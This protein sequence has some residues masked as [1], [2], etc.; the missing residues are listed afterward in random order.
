MP[1]TGRSLSLLLWRPPRRRRRVSPFLEMLAAVLVVGVVVGSFLFVL[2]ARL[3]QP[4]GSAP[5]PTSTP[6]TIPT[7]VGSPSSPTPAGPANSLQT[8]HMIDFPTAWPLPNPTA[9]YTPTRCTPLTN[10]T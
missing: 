10:V 7:V 5:K 6:A 1:R 4:P 8:I 3:H 9:L 2:A